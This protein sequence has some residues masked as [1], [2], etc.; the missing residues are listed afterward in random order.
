MKISVDLML[1]AVRNQEGKFFRSKGYGGYGQTWVDDIKSAKIYT[2][3]GQ[4]RSR[5]TWFSN[6]YPEFGIPDVIELHVTNGTILNEQGRVVK[7]M[8][9]KKREEINR[10][11]GNAQRKINEAQEQLQRAQ[12]KKDLIKNQQEKIEKLKDDLK[13]I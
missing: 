6:N 8:A 9:K 13:K 7:A 10:E 11:I 3:L 2:K 5:V 4:A 12:D 1:Y